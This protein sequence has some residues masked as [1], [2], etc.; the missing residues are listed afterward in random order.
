MLYLCN[1]EAHDSHLREITAQF[2]WH[3]KDFN[4][5]CELICWAVLEHRDMDA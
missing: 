1:T 4:E 2:S 3:P 5:N